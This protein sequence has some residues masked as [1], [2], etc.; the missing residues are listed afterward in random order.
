MRRSRPNLSL[1]APSAIAAIALT[2]PSAVADLVLWTG[3]GNDHQWHTAANWWP[4]APGEFDDAVNNTTDQIFLL[5]GALVKSI[6]SQGKVQVLGAGLLRLASD[7]SFDGGLVMYGNTDLIVILNYGV[8][9]VGGEFAFHNGTIQLENSI[10]SRGQLE[11]V[12]TLVLK[13][14]CTMTVYPEGTHHLLGGS[15]INQGTLIVKPNTA[16]TLGMHQDYSSVTNF[17]NDA[18]GSFYLEQNARVADMT[19]TLPD[20][21]PIN[22]GNSVFE[23]DG[24]L[25]VTDGVSTIESDISF[26][27]PGTILL[28]G[29]TF[30]PQSF[31][32]VTAG[33]QLA[34]GSY[35]I[36]GGS[37]LVTHAGDLTSLGSGAT[38]WLGGDGNF[39]EGLYALQENFGTLRISQGSFIIAPYFLGTFTN[40]GTLDVGG[41]GTLTV[42]GTFV[43][44]ADG[45]LVRTMTIDGNAASIGTVESVLSSTVAG[46]LVIHLPNEYSLDPGMELP[47][48]GVAPLGCCIVEG[49]FSSVQAGPTQET[50]SELVYT[51][52]LVK[53]VSLS[54]VCLGDLDANGLV[55]GADLAI[56]LSSW[57]GSGV[58]D[59]NGDGLV[60]GADLAILLSAWGLC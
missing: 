44:A 24:L 33:H 40:H 8:M 28:Q 53:L 5:N 38:V 34:T 52:R 27:S 11:G 36:L 13:P 4:H 12:G 35:L 55:N 22:G 39:M 23:N 50:P 3:A 32:G 56:L 18:S 1:V 59:L 43:N 14:N 49:A 42:N 37:Q 2:A 26:A 41:F 54:T 17:L 30:D 9:E 45:T 58:A 29:A 10:I 7:S 46:S 19:F 21:T 51:E 60:D 16:L 20:G 15:T 6:H 31:T 25:S 48:V 57:G 47:I